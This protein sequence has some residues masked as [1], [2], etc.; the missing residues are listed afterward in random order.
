VAA[1]LC[2]IGAVALFVSTFLHWYPVVEGAYFNRS[3]GAPHD[4]AVFGV[5]A[6]L[7]AW[8]S[9]AVVDLALAACVA[10]GLWAAATLLRR[11]P[12]VST[13]AT[14]IAAGA[15]GLGLVVWR[16]VDQP[17]DLSA[18]GPG[19]VLAACALLTI[20]FGGVTAALAA[21]RDPR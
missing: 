13:G 16:L 10:A 11:G 9:F 5:G 2:A 14:A 6:W 18:T 1:S 21:R 4:R 12:H 3:V 20:A 19:P 17:F 8:E 7:N 15:I